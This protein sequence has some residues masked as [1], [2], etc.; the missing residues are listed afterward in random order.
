MVDEEAVGGPLGAPNP[1]EGAVKAVAIPVDDKAQ[2]G[3]PQEVNVDARKCK[4]D[5][6]DD[7]AAHPDVGENVGGHPSWL[8]VG[9]PHEG[10]FFYSIK[11]GSLDS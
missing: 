9:E 11:D 6:T 5:G 3:E 1:C 8:P 4:T 7:C 2:R 10:L